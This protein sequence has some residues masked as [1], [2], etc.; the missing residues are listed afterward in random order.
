[1]RWQEVYFDANRAR[2]VENFQALKSRINDVCKQV[3]RDPEEVNLVVASKYA[4]P[5]QLKALIPYGLNDIGE[6]CAADLI[7]KKNAVD[8]NIRWHFIGHLQKNKTKKVVGNAWLIH[9]LDSV[10]LA[11]EVDRRAGEMG[12][13]QDALLQVNISKEESKFGFG[14]EEVMEALPQ[15]AGLK[16][17][18][19]TGLMTIAPFIKDYEI[20]RQIFKR[21]RAI[22]E[23]LNIMGFSNIKHLSMG[24]SNDYEIAIEEGAT[25]IRIGSAI[26]S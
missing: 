9:S 15:V 22:K 25:M 23:E 1:V 4:T 11:A 17:V 21:L 2:L 26:F 24:M 13:V 16:N 7:I 19:I 20:I 5:E 12:K 10:E 3:G 8:K 18:N 6:N 14:E